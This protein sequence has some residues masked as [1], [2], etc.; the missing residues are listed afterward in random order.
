[1]V[2]PR[3]ASDFFG[4]VLAL[5][6]LALVPLF[7]Y[8]W[9]HLGHKL[10]EERLAAALFGATQIFI[11]M[12]Q[13]FQQTLQAA[14]RVGGLA[15]ANVIAKVL[16]GGGTFLAV[17]LEAPFWVLP[18]PMLGAEILKA[19]FLW[20]ATRDAIGLRFKLDLTAT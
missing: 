12:N 20:W 9:F 19:G 14:S 6:T 15:I 5:R 2:R 18:L 1:A 13:T 17:T 7:L 8:G 11:V 3:H 4:G 16:W 10:P